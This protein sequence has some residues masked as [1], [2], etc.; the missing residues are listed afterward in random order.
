M[1]MRVSPPNKVSRWFLGVEFNRDLIVIERKRRKKKTNHPGNIE[2]E[3][4][5]LFEI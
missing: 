1:L 3:V 5:E 4:W 2:V